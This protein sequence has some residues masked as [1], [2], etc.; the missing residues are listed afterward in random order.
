MCLRCTACNQRH[1][2]HGDTVH[3]TSGM[4]AARHTQRVSHNV[5]DLVA[6]VRSIR[7]CRGTSRS[8]HISKRREASSSFGATTLDLRK[9]LDTFCVSSSI[10]VQAD[11]LATTY[12]QGYSKSYSTFGSLRFQNWLERLAAVK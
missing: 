5:P 1:I 9:V 4:V 12:G 8:V 10:A 3:H 2:T 11:A 6:V 7:I